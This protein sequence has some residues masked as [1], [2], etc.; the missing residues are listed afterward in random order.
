MRPRYVENRAVVAKVERRNRVFERFADIQDPR[1]TVVEQHAEPWSDIA[2]E[3][4]AFWPG[5]AKQRTHCAR[6][7]QPVEPLEGVFLYDAAVRDHYAEHRLRGAIR[8][9]AE[10]RGP[11]STRVQCARN[12]LRHTRREVACVYAANLRRVGSPG[13]WLPGRVAN[14]GG[15][16]P[17]KAVGRI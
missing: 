5:S 15:A 12:K 11:D 4:I 1:R 16:D 2:V 17:I 13:Q 3:L 8:R 14:C 10:K 6:R 9:V 7:C